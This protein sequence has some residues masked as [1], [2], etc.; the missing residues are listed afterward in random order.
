M[1]LVK[2]SYWFYYS[3]FIQTNLAH[4]LTIPQGSSWASSVKSF[5][6]GYKNYYKMNFLNNLIYGDIAY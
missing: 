2:H 4:E 6:K 3:D 1:S 5:K